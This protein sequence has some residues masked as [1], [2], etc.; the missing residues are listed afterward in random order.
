MRF[1][2]T[3]HMQ[4]GECME[5]TANGGV[6]GS[7]TS[8]SEGWAY[9]EFA[10]ADVN[11]TETFQLTVT[12]GFTN[13]ARLVVIGGGGG[14]GWDG[15]GN[16]GNG[17]GGGGAAVINRTGQLFQGTYSIQVGAGGAP[18]DADN[19]SPPLRTYNGGN[20]DYSEILGGPY[21]GTDR[22]K[23]L[24][25]KGGYGA[26]ADPLYLHGG[27][28]ATGFTGGTNSGL[29]AGG[30][31]GFTSNGSNGVSNKAGN[32]GTG[33]TVTLPYTSPSWL[34]TSK[35][36]GGGG[37]A[38][39]DG[40]SSIEQGYGQD[41]GG[42]FSG[43]GD[44]YSGGGGGGGRDFPA[45]PPGGIGCS[46][47][48]GI[49]IIYYPTGSCKEYS[50]SVLLYTGSDTASACGS[51]TSTPFYIEKN[52]TLGTGNTIYQD[53]FLFTPVV[54]GYYSDKSFSYFVTSSNGKI[55][56][57]Q[58]CTDPIY[59][60]YNSNTGSILPSSSYLDPFSWV[61]NG[62]SLEAWSYAN[63]YQGNSYEPLINLGDESAGGDRDFF[64]IRYSGTGNMTARGVYY[65]GTSNNNTTPDYTVP[66][67]GIWIHTVFTWD[68]DTSQGLLYIDG[69]LYAS[70]SISTITT[71][72]NNPEVNI[73]RTDSGVD[74]EV[75]VGEAYVY[76][77][78]LSAAAV[79]A[80][81]ENTK[82]RYVGH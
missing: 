64:E 8:G 78:A 68:K 42:G 9:H 1:I 82:S 52:T 33:T 75:V 26:V 69:A 61:D 44:R 81:Y 46:G 74:R 4:S 39:R 22:L 49:V 29:W 25:G 38:A 28:S 51:Q 37:G 57:T 48:D 7:F 13:R 16:L 54:D 67:T 15:T 3:T 2:P 76:G 32:G 5:V 73:S 36:V 70:S 53:K 55:I 18:P 23:S 80:S 60:Y 24:G 27:D 21:T 14:G 62:V 43:D 59:S 40:V 56:N 79:S 50:E 63:G 58:E 66:G 11:T 10:C 20:G 30:G 17:G 77:S 47:G 31:G 65:D 6:S 19:V 12:K 45:T 41:G 35:G 34:T 71:E 72:L